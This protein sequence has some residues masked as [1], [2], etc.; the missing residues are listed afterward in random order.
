MSLNCGFQARMCPG[1]VPHAVLVCVLSL[2][3]SCGPTADVSECYDDSAMSSDEPFGP[4]VC[5]VAPTELES[6]P[7]SDY[8]YASILLPRERGECP[9]LCAMDLDTRLW[10]VFKERVEREGLAEGYD[11]SCLDDGYEVLRR[12]SWESS[13]DECVY[14]MWI[15]TNCKIDPYIE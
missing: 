2:S 13:D 14:R 11:A 4:Y 10:E 9:K 7:Y 12:C 8:G 5:G 6:S 1:V 3:I 15:A